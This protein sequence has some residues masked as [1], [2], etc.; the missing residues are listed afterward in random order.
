MQPEMRKSKSTVPFFEDDLYLDHVIKILRRV[1]DILVEVFVKDLCPQKR[2]EAETLLWRDRRV[3][4]RKKNIEKKQLNMATDQMCRNQK[5]KNE[6]MLPITPSKKKLENKD[7]LFIN[8]TTVIMTVIMIL[9]IIIINLVIYFT[10][11]SCYAFIRKS[12]SWQISKDLDNCRYWD[13]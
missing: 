10:D 3:L 13:L 9:V 1:G 2:T 11:T 6:E 5:M 4:L 12:V 7:G 8:I